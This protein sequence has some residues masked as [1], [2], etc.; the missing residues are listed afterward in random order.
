MFK[1]S[2][3]LK[4]AVADLRELTNNPL[5]CESLTWE[6]EEKITEVGTLDF[7]N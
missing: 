7:V 5:Q 6:N 4:V 1:E 2:G 3:L